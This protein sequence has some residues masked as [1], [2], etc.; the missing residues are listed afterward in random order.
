MCMQLENYSQADDIL[1]YLQGDFS[2]YRDETIHA[3]REIHAIKSAEIIEQAVKLLP[4][5]GE[6]FFKIANA[7][8]KETMSKLNAEFSN[9]PDGHLCD[10][11]RKYANVHREELLNLK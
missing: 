2:E 1:S 10:L 8:T 4:E 7:E 6:W 5:N 11:I 9:Y 3:L